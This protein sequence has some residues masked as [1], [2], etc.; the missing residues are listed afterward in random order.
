MSCDNR[1]VSVT[2]GQGMFQL[3]Y[4]LKG[5]SCPWASW[6]MG[7]FKDLKLQPTVCLDFFPSSVLPFIAYI[8]KEYF[9]WQ[10]TNGMDW[11]YLFS[12]G[13]YPNMRYLFS[14]DYQTNGKYSMKKQ[15]KSFQESSVK[16]IGSL[17]K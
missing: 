6:H 14:T 7:K 4:L 2:A 3:F 12:F 8:K 9:L 16:V 5:Q 1:N 10:Y 11:H 15:Y 13:S 17:F